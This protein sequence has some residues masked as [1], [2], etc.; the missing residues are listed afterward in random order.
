MSAPHALKRSRSGTLDA[1]PATTF[2]DQQSPSSS[3]IRPPL[4]KRVKTETSL[5]SF[6]DE[7][8]LPAAQESV[9][10]NSRPLLLPESRASGTSVNPLLDRRDSRHSV[11][12]TA[13]Q[14]KPLQQEAV[15]SPH[16]QADTTSYAGSVFCQ[17]HSPD[18]N[19][20]SSKDQPV[21]GP[22]STMSESQR[23]KVRDAIQ[24]EFNQLILK[25]HEELRLIEQEQAKVQIA[26]EQL[27]RCRQ[28]PYPGHAAS[29]DSVDQLLDG[30]GP[31][32]ASRPGN[33]Q[34]S[35]PAGWGVTDGPYTKHYARWLIPDPQF[36][37]DIPAEK[38]RVAN[39]GFAGSRTRANETSTLHRRQRQS[40]G[41]RNDVATSTL[42]DRVPNTPKEKSASF[43]Q[44]MKRDDNGQW[45]QLV[46]R[47]C[48]TETFRSVQGF[49]N[50]MRIQ[51]EIRLR[52]HAHA[53]RDYGVAVDGPSA[54]FEK[55]SQDSSN[56]S[57]TIAR[58]ST[59]QAHPLNAPS[60]GQTKKVL[61]SQARPGVSNPSLGELIE[62]SPL[63]TGAPKSEE[64]G[65]TGPGAVPSSSIPALSNIAGKLG[66]SQNLE[67]LHLQM[68]KRVD[69]DAIEPLIPDSEVEEDVPAQSGSEWRRRP[70]QMQI[71]ARAPPASGARVQNKPPSIQV[72]VDVSAGVSHASTSF[73]HSWSSSPHGTY[74]QGTLSPMTFVSHQDTQ[75]HDLSPHANMP[76]L[77][78]DHEDDEDMEDEAKSVIEHP[79]V[80]QQNVQI[81]SEHGYHDMSD[82]A[83]EGKDSIP[84]W[85]P[86]QPFDHH[87]FP[88]TSPQVPVEKK[89]RGRPNK[90]GKEKAAK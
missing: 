48:G 23:L 51:H 75:M 49:M 11:A 85:H 68:S 65:K 38:S 47:E 32:I 31:A 30:T 21:T 70:G 82:V 64:K 90:K 60:I 2:R 86:H 79:V 35:S 69:L 59:G 20:C 84:D 53:A 26:L 43:P 72:P 5:P 57:V 44:I 7:Q 27:R 8:A 45:V 19:R 56:S 13:Q 22:S 28:I 58:P 10:G 34:P 46:C 6:H 63:D 61:Q 77:V 39:G 42:T 54:P 15:N 67:Q 74:R 18:H 41:G 62:L 50:H 9:A 33:P 14:S 40:T 25:K 24:W 71:G 12:N 66:G 29:A 87:H 83:A 76:G 16:H 88:N 37:A 3:E 78:T 55:P 89:R 4:P 36:D 73:D 17:G 80:G 52:S 1:L 81:I